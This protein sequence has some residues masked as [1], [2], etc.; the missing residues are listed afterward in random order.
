MRVCGGGGHC[1]CEPRVEV[2][3]KI[4]KSGELE[5]RIE[6]IVKMQESKQL[7]VGGLGWM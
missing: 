6:V 4:K 7:G 3:L 5:P 1:E 2:I